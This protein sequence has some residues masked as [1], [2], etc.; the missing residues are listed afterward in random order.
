MDV[1][2]VSAP[3]AMPSL[4]MVPRAS[5]SALAVSTAISSDQLTLQT[6]ATGTVPASRSLLPPPT[7]E[8]NGRFT[9][10]RNAHGQSITLLQKEGSRTYTHLSSQ[11]LSFILNVKADNSPDTLVFS[12]MGDQ[13]TRNSLIPN[14]Y[15]HITGEGQSEMRFDDQHNLVVQLKNGDQFLI[16]GRNGETL[17]T[18][19]FRVTFNPDSN[20]HDFQVTYTGQHPLKKKTSRGDRIQW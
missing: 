7:R 12:H 11:G 8:Q 19:T 20:G 1:A 14:Q 13:I 10:M 6:P 17:L 4:R 16:D 5:Q 9:F 18:D 15:Y 3:V 2:S